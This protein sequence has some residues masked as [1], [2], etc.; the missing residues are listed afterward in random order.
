MYEESITV[1]FGVEAFSEDHSCVTLK[2]ETNVTVGCPFNRHIVS[3]GKPTR[4]SSFKNFSYVISS[5]QQREISPENDE[6]SDKTVAYDL[7]KLG[8][9][10]SVQSNEPFKPII[11]L[12]D[13]E[14]F[15]KEVD[16]N[17]VLR[18]Q[19]GRTG[20]KYSKTMKEAGCMRE[21]Q[22]W[23]KM[24]NAMKGGSIESAWSRENYQSCFQESS[25]SSISAA[26][27][28]KQYEILNSSGAASHIVWN[29]VGTFVFLLKVLDPEFSFCNLTL[30][31]GVQV[32]GVRSAMQEIPTFVVLGSAC[33][34]IIIL[35]LSVYRTAALYSQ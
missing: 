12:Y 5:G 1:L 32:H 17:Y 35:V 31:F 29:D 9:P 22:S 4:C 2:T 16:A 30:E 19:H 6:V 11:D 21:A 13:G 10:L 34:T 8:C 7:L 28:D 27:L 15:V 3:R 25:D 14:T 26:N 23:E 18:E 33:L 24:I 20:Y